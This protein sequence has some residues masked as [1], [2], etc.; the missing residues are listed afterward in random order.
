[1]AAEP[2]ADREAQLD[3]GGQLPPLVSRARQALTKQFEEAL[4]QIIDSKGPP[5]S[6]DG[7]GGSLSEKAHGP[8][9]AE[10]AAGGAEQESEEE[11]REWYGDGCNAAL[12]GAAVAIVR[13]QPGLV[14]HSPPDSPGRTLLWCACR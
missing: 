3:R 12:F 14:D 5:D 13:K 7:A 4:G 10:E 8:K 11:A 6:E 2:N 9:G 1:M